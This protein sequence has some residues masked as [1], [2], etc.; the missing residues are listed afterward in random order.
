MKS[1]NGSL[2]QYPM[3]SFDVSH[4]NMVVEADLNFL[5]MALGFNSLPGLGLL[6]GTD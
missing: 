2:S 5:P 4:I 3:R 1:K 6:K